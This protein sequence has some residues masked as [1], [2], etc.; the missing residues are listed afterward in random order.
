[1]A[2]PLSFLPLLFV[3][4]FLN[5]E[6]P[7]QDH[8]SRLSFQSVPRNLTFTDVVGTCMGSH[9][10]N[11]QLQPLSSSAGMLSL[12][13]TLSGCVSLELSHVRPPPWSACP[14]CLLLRQILFLYCAL[15]SSLPLPV[16]SSLRHTLSVSSFYLSKVKEPGTGMIHFRVTS[17]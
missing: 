1:M 10:P 5:I 15:A 12:C 16:P 4:V 8:L 11:I 9:Y 3:V 17:A 7:H 14:A 6:D 13:S 2:L